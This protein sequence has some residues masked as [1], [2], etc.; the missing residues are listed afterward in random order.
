MK[1]NITLSLE[2]SVI[3]DA[4]VLAVERSLSVSA[5]LAQELARVVEHDRE[6]KLARLSAIDDLEQG[7]QL[8]GKPLDRDAFYDR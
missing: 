8:G 1:Q 5:L 3:R 6:Y 4:K 2:K 7:L